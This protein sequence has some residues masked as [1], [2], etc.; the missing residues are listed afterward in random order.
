MLT[1]DGMFFVTYLVLSLTFC[2]DMPFFSNRPDPV[3]RQTRNSTY[4]HKQ[5]YTRL[6]HSTCIT[7]PSKKVNFEQIAPVLC[8]ESINALGEKGRCF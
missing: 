4:S 2:F 8:P 6:T 1:E 3:T 5:K 7:L